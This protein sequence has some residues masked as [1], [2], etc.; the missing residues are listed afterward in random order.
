MSDTAAK[1]RYE[2]PTSHIKVLS[3]SLL[4]SQFQLP[5]HTRVGKQQVMAQISESL[6]CTQPTQTELLAPDFGLR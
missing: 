6:P 3:S 5:V 1:T 2:M 4:H